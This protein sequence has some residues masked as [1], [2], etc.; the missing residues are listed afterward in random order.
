M[1]Q[2]ATRRSRAGSLGQRNTCRDGLTINARL[3]R[4]V[5]CWWVFKHSCKECC[6]QL[7]KLLVC[8]FSAKP[9]EQGVSGSRWWLVFHAIADT[10]KSGVPSAMTCSQSHGIEILA[11]KGRL[12]RAAG[13]WNAECPTFG[14]HPGCWRRNTVRAQLRTN[15][16]CYRDFLVACKARGG[17]Q[18]PSPT[19]GG[20]PTV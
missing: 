19:S 13:L 3:T 12:R 18:H 8:V 11:A 14:H 1:Y 2:S 4:A 9:I 20:M 16:Q 6:P 17:R 7:L 5:W 10:I 15:Q